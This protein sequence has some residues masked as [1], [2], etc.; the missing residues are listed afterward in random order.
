MPQPSQHDLAA[1]FRDLHAR[2]AGRILVLPNAWDAMSARVVEEAGARAIA[3]TSAGIA[4]ALGYPD[5]QKIPRDAML[6]QVALIARAVRVPVTADVESGY[7]ATPE[8]AAETARGVID[9]GAVGLNLEDAPGP[10]GAP[11]A[12]AHRHAERIAAVR[13][14]AR[15]AGVALFVNA[16]TDIYVRKVGDEG[17]RLD[18]T[19]RRAR[20]YVEAGADGVFVPLAP[21]DVIGRLAAAIDAPLNVIAGPGSPTIAELQALGVARASLGP[22]LARSVM[23]HVRRAAAE[24]LG[25]GTYEALREQV[26]SPEAN[27]LFAAP[28]RGDGGPRGD[29]PATGS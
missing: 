25:A 27:A 1:R 5:G 4:W 9:A 14:A 29:V 19:V 18:E 15:E 20:L 8:D 24:V 26:P 16:R 7:G 3:T 28:E 17:A 12:D 21:N 6:R 13:A 23:A 10:D 2:G 11:V 22:G